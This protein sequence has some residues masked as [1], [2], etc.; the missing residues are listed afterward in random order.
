MIT[1]L[2][3][4]EDRKENI[5]PLKRGRK[6]GKLGLSKA[7]HKGLSTHIPEEET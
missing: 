6:A 4:F 5:V 2:S 3:D 7:P 1:N